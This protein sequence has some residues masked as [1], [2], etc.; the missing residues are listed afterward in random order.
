MDY[1]QSLRFLLLFIFYYLVGLVQSRSMLDF[2]LQTF[3]IDFRQMLQ[4]RYNEYAIGTL[5]LIFQVFR[6]LQNFLTK[7]RGPMNRLTEPKTYDNYCNT[8]TWI[9]KVFLHLFKMYLKIVFR[10][11]VQTSVMVRASNG[12]RS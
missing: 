10:S 8:D 11:E 5:L 7:Q 4:L 3:T 2:C 6:K 1:F 9:L 12:N